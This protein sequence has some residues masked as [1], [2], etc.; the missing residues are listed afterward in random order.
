M[1]PR[2]KYTLMY[3]NNSTEQSEAQHFEMQRSPAGVG[4]RGRCD[5]M[6][7]PCSK[8]RTALKVSDT[9]VQGNAKLVRARAEGVPVTVCV[10]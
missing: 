3:P 6:G 10:S 5:H 7:Q 8:A 9:P 4:V 1:L 2:Q